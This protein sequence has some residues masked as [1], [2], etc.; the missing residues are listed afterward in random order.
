MVTE[1]FSVGLILKPKCEHGELARAEWVGRIFQ[2]GL[3]VHRGE[4]WG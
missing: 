2:K 4:Q 1:G 3:G